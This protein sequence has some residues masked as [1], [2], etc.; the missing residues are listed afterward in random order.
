MPIPEVLQSSS[1]SEQNKSQVTKD[2]SNS[3]WSLQIGS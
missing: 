1:V 2:T 3:P